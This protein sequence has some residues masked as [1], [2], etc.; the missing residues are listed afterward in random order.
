[1]GESAS[2]DVVVTNVAASGALTIESIGIA[3]PDAAMFADGFD[4]ASAPTL[5]PGESV[6]VTVEFSPSASGSRSATLRVN[7][8][9]PD[10]LGI[11]LSGTGVAPSPGAAPLVA[12]PASVSLPSTPVGQAASQDVVLRNGGAS[13]TIVVASTD[14]SGADAPMF[15]DAFDDGTPRSLGP[16]EAVT[17]AVTF[18]PTASGPRSAS[19]NVAHTG[20]NT[21][22][23]VPLAGDAGPAGSSTVLYRVNAGGPAVAGPV[24]TPSWSEDSSAQPSP[25]ANAAATGN[26]VATRTT[27][28]DLTHPSVPAGTPIELFQTERWDM[29]AGPNLAY[30]FP[31]PSGVAVE[32]RVYLAEMHAPLHVV[33]GRVFDVNVEGATAFRDVDVFAA[34]APIAA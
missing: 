12:D 21:P 23:R 19:L 8:S 15:S 20:S 2:R 31:V 5:D 9:G 18:R 6:T 30:A 14:I 7:H 32:V 33:G 25:Y 34:W 29:A 28:V 24:G 1:M 10:A 22:L 16:G 27:P 4:D 17:V 11:P 26:L 13:G 3:G